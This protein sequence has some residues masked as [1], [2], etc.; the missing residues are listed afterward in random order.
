MKKTYNEAEYEQDSIRIMELIDQ[1]KAE[2][3]AE[4][5][6][7]SQKRNEE[8]AEEYRNRMF[9]YIGRSA[10]V[11]AIGF[12]LDTAMAAELIAPVLAV[13]ATYICACYF[14]WCLSKTVRYAK[15]AGAKR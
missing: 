9:H 1:R 12:L 10:A 15:R 7:T 6:D 3:V 11:A 14:G 4:E 5:R 8:R 13:P 2:R